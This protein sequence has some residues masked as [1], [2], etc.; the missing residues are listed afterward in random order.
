MGRPQTRPPMPLWAL[1]HPAAP[2]GAGALQ[3]AVV[4]YQ[5]IRGDATSLPLADDSVERLAAYYVEKWNGMP[6]H[7]TFT[8]PFDSGRRLSYWPERVAA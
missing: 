3:G 2:T 4:T 6:S 1:R 7:E 8:T 5:L